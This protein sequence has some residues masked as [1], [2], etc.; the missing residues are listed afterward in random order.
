MQLHFSFLARVLLEVQHTHELVQE[1][2][3]KSSAC[4]FVADKPPIQNISKLNSI[5]IIIMREPW[6]NLLQCS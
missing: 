2:G 3:C 5:M 4:I 1:R 6:Q